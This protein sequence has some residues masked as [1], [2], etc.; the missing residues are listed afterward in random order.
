MELIVR[1]AI[2]HPPYSSVNISLIAEELLPKLI[3]ITSN[4][5]AA[6]IDVTLRHWANE[7]VRQ[8]AALGLIVI[9][10]NKMR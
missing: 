3:T 7:A 8:A 2:P 10:I 1:K 5:N 4:P 6:F 9:C